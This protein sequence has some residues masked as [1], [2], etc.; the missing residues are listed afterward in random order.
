ME[1]VITIWTRRDF[2]KALSTFTVVSLLPW[3]LTGRFAMADSRDLGFNGGGSSLYGDWSSEV[4]V[5]AGTWEPGTQLAVEAHLQFSQALL[6]NLT[7]AGLPAQA[8]LLLVTSERCFDPNGCLRLPSDDRMS[9]LLTPAGLAIEGGSTGAISQLTGGRFRNP[10]D[11]LA[12]VP[13]DN[14]RQDNGA[15]VADFALDCT[16]PND[17]PPGIYRLRLD[18][19]VATGKRRLSLN[20]EGFAASQ[21]KSDQ[22]SLL[23][24]PP[25]PCNGTGT[26][27][28]S[29]NAAAIQPRIY[30]VLLSGYN[31][32]GSYGTVADED[33]GFFALSNRNIIADQ[34]ILP[35]YDARGNVRSYDLEPAFYA[36]IIDEQRNIPWDCTSGELSIQVTD[37]SGRTTDL[38]TAPYRQQKGL[39][40]TTGNR[41]FT[42][43][44]PS[45]YGQ[46]TASVSGWV[47]DQWG[48]HYQGG[49]TYH[50]WIANRLTLATATFQG[51]SYPVGSRYGR[52]IAFAPAVPADVTVKVDLYPDSDASRVKSLAYSGVASAGGVFGAAQ[53][54]QP[55]IL[56]APGEY[57]ARIQATYTDP[58]GNLWVCG[59]RHAGV[60][61]S[62]DDSL[63]AHG[64]MLKVGNQLVERGETHTEGY[65]ESPDDDSHLN[66]INFPYNRGD[67][68]LIASDGQGANKI[69]P[70]LTYEI[71]G[72]NQP[73]DPKIQPIG[74]SNI[75]IATSNGLSPHLY[76]EYITD[77]AYYYGAGPRPGFMS[78]FLVAE[79]GARGPYWPTS[80]TNVGGQIGASN[81]GDHP[82]EIYRLVGGVALRPGSG[83]SRYAGYLASAFILPR[84]SNNNR[85]IA[86]GAEEVTG[87][88]GRQ[89]RFFLVATRPGMV[90]EAGTIYTPSLQIDPIL[91]AQ[92]SFSLYYPDG[93]VKTTTGTGD[94]SGSFVA[95]DHWTLDQPGLYTYTIKAVWQGYPGCMPGLPDEGGYI[96]VV[97][98][99][100]PTGATR[101]ALSMPEQ[102]WFTVADGLQVNG[103]SAADRVYYAAVTPGAVV[104]QGSLPVTGGGFSYY[105]DPVAINQRIPIY[106]IANL[107]N[108]KSEIERVIHLTFFAA[109]PGPGGTLRHCYARVIL[110]GTNA[111]CV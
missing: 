17:T 74:A 73:Y 63:V 60:V 103:S 33:G 13:I 37:P 52:D 42:A 91:P 65:M 110:R 8:L 66:H 61:Y 56:D 97:D 19:G 102:Q 95:T 30:W 9:T 104:D 51:M 59:M 68:L 41:Q 106:D 93:S 31:S 35:L 62:P 67:V 88:D 100:Q 58:E 78:R 29:V 64:K 57:H 23:Y 55:F 11:Q 87:A 72:D 43:W 28:N 82:G 83:Q 38:G 75:R 109:E 24:S 16:L 53:G 20:G 34:V 108:G 98:K 32:N 48:N 85:V 1:G 69:E 79:D 71:T 25:I 54:L 5:S 4:Y 77:L 96:F 50:F 12:K 70:V 92:I 94:A 6:D 107:K 89:F 22:L 15:L 2:L 80:S 46:Y 105:F 26:D 47:A 14:L 44:K 84:G 86:P 49:G 111:I 3:P 76:P 81:N 27:G 36:D 90:Y 7:A 40:P 21:E 101:L 45:G 10:V 18:F 39:W 99:D